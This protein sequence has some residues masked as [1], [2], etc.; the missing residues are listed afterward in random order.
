MVQSLEDLKEMG[1]LFLLDELDISY[2]PKMQGCNI[3]RFVDALCT[4]AQTTKLNLSNCSLFNADGI[5][6]K[7]LSIKDAAK[8]AELQGRSIDDGD[9]IHMPVSDQNAL[10][11]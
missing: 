4:L 8:V 11:R 10:F 2:N 5:V 9:L 3:A 1:D 7:M 6:T